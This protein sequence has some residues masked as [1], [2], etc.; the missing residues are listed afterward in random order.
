MFNVD[1]ISDR[2]PFIP[3]GYVFWFWLDTRYLNKP[4]VNA[5]KMGIVIFHRKKS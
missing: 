5:F 4:G 1:I 2:K 3:S